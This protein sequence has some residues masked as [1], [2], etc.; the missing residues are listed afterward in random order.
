MRGVCRTVAKGLWSRTGHGSEAHTARGVSPYNSAPVRHDPRRLCLAAILVATLV[1]GVARVG[2]ADWGLPVSFHVDEKGFV[3]WEAIGME[4]R[5]LTSGDYRPNAS[6]YGPLVYEV[7]VG[8]KWLLFGGPDE[9]RPVAR[10]YRDSAQYHQTA[11]DALD[12]DAPYSFAAW[13]HAL[14]IFT[15]LLGAISILLMARAAWRLQGPWAGASAA[16]IT[17]LAPGLIQVGHFY[18]ADAL[19]IPEIAMLLDACSLLLVGGGA[20]SAAYAGIALGLIAVTKLPGMLLGLA[21]VYALAWSRGVTDGPLRIGSVL[22]HRWWLRWIG[23]GFDAR[24]LVAMVAMIAVYV[25]VQP[26]LI[27]G[28]GPPEGSGNRSGLFMLSTYFQE[29]EF[30]FYDW[31]FTYNDRWPTY[32]LSTILPYTLGVPVLLAVGASLRARRSSLATLGLVAALPSFLLVAGWGVLTIRHVLPA[33]PGMILG[34]SAV[35]AS[36]LRP[37]ELD[38]PSQA[39]RWLA[40]AA[41]VHVS[42]YGVAWALMFREP[43]PRLLASAWLAEHAREN[44]VVVLEPEAPYSAPLGINED[45]MGVPGFP[46]PHLRARRLWQSWPSDA[47]VPAHVD[48]MLRDARF[49]VIGDFYRR[50]GLDPSAPTRAP[51]HAIFYEAVIREETGYHLVASFLREPTL[52]PLHWS[53]ADAEALSVDFDHM[54][55][56]IYE[57]DGAYRSPFEAP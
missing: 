44:D 24:F 26:W 6:V 46:M 22:R 19:L 55:V 27:D 34:A 47:E 35:L 1:G 38:R 28:R 15:G 39:R 37:S 40:G 9:A 36:A 12:A 32:W 54:P 13:T 3:L 49:L 29:R 45:W 7:A 11:F 16:I 5:G 14:R 52:G 30:V 21:L 48:G 42:L 4:W 50:R 2:T 56:W 41:L 57:R 20:G 33:V 8:M 25:L 53:E 10:L 23:A 43:D 51:M 31:R 17:A 18:T